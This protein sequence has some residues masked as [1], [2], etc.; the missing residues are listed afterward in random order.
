MVYG[1]IERALEKLIRSELYVLVKEERERI[2]KGRFRSRW[3]SK[4]GG[5]LASSARFW[6][7]VPYDQVVLTCLFWRMPQMVPVLVKAGRHERIQDVVLTMHALTL[8]EFLLKR[9]GRR[10]R[11]QLQGVLDEKR[12]LKEG[13]AEGEGAFSKESKEDEA[14]TGEEA[15]Q[16][17]EGAGA[18]SKDAEADAGE[19][20]Q[21]YEGGADAV[22]KDAEADAG[23]DA[24]QHEE[25]AR[26]QGLQ[27]ETEA[28]EVV[29]EQ[30]EVLGGPG[31]EVEEKGKEESA[32]E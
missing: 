30:D 3:R 6:N 8:K 1:K 2:G 24:E 5:G 25:G 26:A 11:Q 23:A 12:R 9:V 10:K 17:E 14:A 4:F 21:Q 27:R 20:V 16:H 15:Q 28:I 29:T 18:V 13:K 7:S 19:E 32:R 31:G 22:S